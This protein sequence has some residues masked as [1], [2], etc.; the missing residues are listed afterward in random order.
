MRDIPLFTH[1][2][3][4]AVIRSIVRHWKGAMQQL[5]SDSG[6]HSTYRNVRGSELHASIDSRLI[7][8][9][10]GIP[11]NRKQGFYGEVSIKPLIIPCKHAWS[12][13]KGPLKLFMDKMREVTAAPQG[14]VT[15]RLI[16][17]QNETLHNQSLLTKAGRLF[18]RSHSRFFGPP[19]V[20]T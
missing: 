10:P 6:A 7:G 16:I 4:N 3:I 11:L 17:P 12:S 5:C 2:V 15:L 8:G 14:Y 19:E 13:P 18:Q 1:G 20:H 9:F